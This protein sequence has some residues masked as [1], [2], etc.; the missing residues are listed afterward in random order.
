[1]IGVLLV[2]SALVK[3][4][5]P[6]AMWLWGSPS[7]QA[8]SAYLAEVHR[9]GLNRD[10]PDAEVLAFGERT[11]LAIVQGA[12]VYRPEGVSEGD[13]RVIAGAAV[14]H[15]CPRAAFRAGDY[16]ARKAR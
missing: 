1:M 7:A 10:R 6:D 3:G 13:V 15:L 5:E 14:R 2:A 4:G 16:L 9:Q 8:Q 12:A 11:C